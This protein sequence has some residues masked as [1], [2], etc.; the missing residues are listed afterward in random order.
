M[1][2]LLVH[3]FGASKP[4]AFVAIESDLL[5]RVADQVGERLLIELF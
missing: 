3:Y 5:V 1:K 4:A 2:A